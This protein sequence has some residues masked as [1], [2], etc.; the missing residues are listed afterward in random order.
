MLSNVNGDYVPTIAS[1]SALPS[2]AVAINIIEFGIDGTGTVVGDSSVP[3]A[4]GGSADRPT[5]NSKDLALKSDVDAITV[6]TL[7]AVPTSRTVNGK[8][9]SGNITL[10]ASDVGAAPATHDHSYIQNGTVGIKVSDSN[11]INFSSNASYI[12]FGYDNRAGSS[13]L[14]DTYKFGTHKGAAEAANGNIECGTVKIGAGK[15][16]YSSSSECLNFTFV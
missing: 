5:Y 11:E 12:Y 1:A 7:G 15:I 9:L 4:M 3:L 2:D 8:A 10:S 14:V 16:S 13:G 6:S